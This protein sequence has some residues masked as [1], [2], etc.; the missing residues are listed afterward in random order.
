MLLEVIPVIVEKLKGETLRNPVK[1]PRLGVW[2]ITAQNEAA[3]FLLEIG[4]AVRIAHGGEAVRGALH[5]FRHD[6]LVL[7]RLKRDR[8]VGQR[9][10]FAR[11]EAGTDDRLFACD[12]ALR[13]FDRDD[14]AA[15]NLDAGD[16]HF[17][18][19]LDTVLAGALGERLGDVGGVGL[20]V[21][22]H[23]GGTDEIGHVHQRPHALDLFRRQEFH[24]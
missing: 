16:R 15:R 6:I 4:A 8:H 24:L 10:D 5:R 18:E 14:T 1:R 7:D 22:R 12:A 20:A 3:D 23:E 9:T 19:Q 11:P 13:G 2:F 17:L 21:G